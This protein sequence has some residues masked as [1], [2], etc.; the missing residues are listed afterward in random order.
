[1]NSLKSGKY[2]GIILGILILVVLS[3]G[4]IFVDGSFQDLS[5]NS[6]NLTQVSTVNGTYSVGNVS[7]K[8]PNNWSVGTD[9]EDGM[10]LASPKN[11]AGAFR[12]MSFAPQFQVQVIPNSDFS[13]YNDLPADSSN[14]SSGIMVGGSVNGE[15]MPVDIININSS[16]YTGI[17]VNSSPSEQEIAGIMK[18]STDPSWNEISN[19]TLKVDG[20]TAYETT[21]IVNSLIPLTIDKRIEQIIF[22][23][24]KYT[25]LMLFQAQNWDFDKEKQNFDMI[26]NSFKVQ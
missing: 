22:V 3:S 1:M 16:I 25:Y 14:N 15:S 12:I 13:N 2:I 10:I 7:F 19:S 9:N 17:S 11:S 18:N 5:D 24:N 26:L 8:C 20:K 6:S 4:C 21:F 23:K